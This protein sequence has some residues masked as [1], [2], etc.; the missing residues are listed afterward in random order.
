MKKLLELAYAMY[1]K[2]REQFWYLVIGVLTTLVDFVVYYV[3][4][5]L[6]P[7]HYLF[8]Y[9]IAWAAAVLFA[10]FP[11]RNLVFRV[12]KKDGIFAQFGQFVSSRVATLVIGEVLMWLLVS[13]CHF[14]DAWMKPVVQ[15]LIVILNYVFSKVFVFRK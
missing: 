15:V 4:E 3:L 11:N 7:L 1:R 13:V 14:S 12:E 5:H 9:W 8:R 10:F 2:Y 6:T